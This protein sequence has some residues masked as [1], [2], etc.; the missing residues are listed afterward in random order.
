MVKASADV[1]QFQCD[2]SQQRGPCSPSVADNDRHVS[3][4]AAS[5]RHVAPLAWQKQQGRQATQEAT[6]E[7]AAHHF[8]VV[9]P[10]QRRQGRGAS[11]LV[12]WHEKAKREEA[13]DTAAS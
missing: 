10:S 11:R 4:P 12:R 3:R 1:S 6:H 9:Q 13:A 5:A 8:Q 2:K 7:Q